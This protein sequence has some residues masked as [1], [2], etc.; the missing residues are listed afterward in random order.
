MAF[1]FMSNI[2]FSQFDKATSQSILNSFDFKSYKKFY[3]VTDFVGTDSKTWHAAVYDNATVTVT[4]NDTYLIIKDATGLVNY[5]PYSKI[6]QISGSPSTD[7]YY[8]TITIFLG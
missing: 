8:S 6:K 3:L 5:V 7:K 1:L 2:A 4:F